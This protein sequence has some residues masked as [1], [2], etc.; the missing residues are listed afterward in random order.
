M[1]LYAEFIKGKK[2]P[3]EGCLKDSIKTTIT[4][5]ILVVIAIVIEG[6]GIGAC[7]E[8]I[9]VPLHHVTPPFSDLSRVVTLRNDC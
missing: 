2:G 1:D 9:F 4:W 3:I 5:V 7:H 8:D 6:G